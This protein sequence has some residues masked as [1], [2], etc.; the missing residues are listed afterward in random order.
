MLD[1]ILLKRSGRYIK[2][3]PV[4]AGP[5]CVICVIASTELKANTVEKIIIPAINETE[6]FPNPIKAA[7]KEISSL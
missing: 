6:L 7:F 2:V 1:D 5:D 3:N 4:F